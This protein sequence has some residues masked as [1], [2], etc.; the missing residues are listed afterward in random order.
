MTV[1]RDAQTFS[2]DKTVEFEPKYGR[3]SVLCAHHTHSLVFND[4]PLHTRVWPSCCET[5]C[6][7]P[8]KGENTTNFIS[9]ALVARQEWPTARV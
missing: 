3:A 9:N 2:S 4:P 5:A 7:L 6:H 8:C 1:Y